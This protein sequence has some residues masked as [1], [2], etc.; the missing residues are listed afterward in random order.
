MITFKWREGIDGTIYP[1]ALKLRREI[2]IE[3][4]NVS[5]EEEIDGKDDECWHI[6]GFEEDTA[7][8]TARL[9]FL[10]DTT[11]KIQRVCVSKSVR[12]KKVGYQ[13]MQAIENWAKSNHIHLMKLSSQDHVIDFYRQVGFEISNEEGYL[14]ANIP[15]HDMEKNIEQN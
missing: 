2:F 12:G 3:E 15:H 5:E 13:L 1:Y 8:A 7:V 4:Q 9:Y 14:D 10:D 11:L 6:V